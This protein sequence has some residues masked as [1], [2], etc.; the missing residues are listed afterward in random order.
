MVKHQ[1]TKK[2]EFLMQVKNMNFIAKKMLA[3]Y[4]IKIKKIELK[5]Y[6]ANAGWDFLD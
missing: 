6:A 5:R 2:T 4:L 1:H 3:Q